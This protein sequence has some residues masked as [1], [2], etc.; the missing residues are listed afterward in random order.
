V[1]ELLTL[2]NNHGAKYFAVYINTIQKYATGCSIESRQHIQ[3]II[4]NNIRKRSLPIKQG[5]TKKEV[6]Q[7]INI[8]RTKET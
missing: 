1:K 7:T 4:T 8:R 2:H 5:K 3:N 6:P